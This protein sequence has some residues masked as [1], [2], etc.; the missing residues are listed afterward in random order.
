M[1]R[2]IICARKQIGES[3][4]DLRCTDPGVPR[5]L[6]AD[7]RGQ[8]LGA[9]QDGGNSDPHSWQPPQRGLDFAELDPVAADLHPVIGA[10]D[11][12]AGAVRPIPGQVAGA[13]PPSA[14]VLDETLRRQIGATAIATRDAA[15]GHPELTGDPVRAVVAGVTDD[16]AGVVGKRGAEGQRRPVRRQLG[17][18]AHLENRVVDRGFG[19]TAQAGEP[20]ARRLDPATG[21]PPRAAPNHRRWVPPA[22]MTAGRGRPRSASPAS[23]A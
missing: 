11:E 1:W 22:P 3:L 14:V 21:E 13:V 2:G 18:V 5:D 9:G 7:R 8:Y 6:E 4:A 15:A 12:F 23:P 10:A 17:G 19:G 16:A 20:Q